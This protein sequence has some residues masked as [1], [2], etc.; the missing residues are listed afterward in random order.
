MGREMRQTQPR[1]RAQCRLA[2]RTQAE[3]P[4][5]ADKVTAR[6][7]ARPMTVIGPVNE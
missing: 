1:Y 3:I 7:P 5:G 4:P 2:F 6:V